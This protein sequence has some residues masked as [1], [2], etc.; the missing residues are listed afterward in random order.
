MRTTVRVL[1]RLRD[2]SIDGVLRHSFCSPELAMAN[3]RVVVLPHH[4]CELHIYAQ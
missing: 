3:I 2:A 1:Q 4:A